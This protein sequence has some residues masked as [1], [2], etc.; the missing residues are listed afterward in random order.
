MDR[1]WITGILTL[2]DKGARGEREDRSGATIR[3]LLAPGPFRVGAYEVIPDDYDLIVGR[4][5]DW[6][7]RD[8]LDLVL[9]TGGTGVSPRDL[10][11][12]ATRAVLHRE[13]PGL[14]EAM[15]WAS[16]QKTPHAALSR[17][18]AGIRGS[19]LIVNLPGSPKAVRENLEAIL[20]ALPHAL[21]KIHGDPSECAR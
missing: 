4:L 17:A 16:L 20:P 18:V 21:E 14:A 11:P 9:T 8:G 5:V 7:D 12:E 10:T 6:C 13:V 1:T 15:R 19:T 3:E 2:S